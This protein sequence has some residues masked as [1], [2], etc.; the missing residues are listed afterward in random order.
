MGRRP[1]L[2]T[3]AAIM[4][5]SLTIAAIITGLHLPG[6]SATLC[7][8]CA[9]LVFV[10]GSGWGLARWYGPYV[11]KSSRWREGISG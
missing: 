6:M 3:S 2:C 9:L 1:L 8:L 5:L 4:A 7:L 10:G 11:L